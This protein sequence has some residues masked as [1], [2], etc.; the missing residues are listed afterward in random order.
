MRLSPKNAILYLQDKGVPLIDLG[1]YKDKT[2][3]NKRLG[4]VL[5]NHKNSIRRGYFSKN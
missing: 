2:K 4:K 5:S 3:S 1:C